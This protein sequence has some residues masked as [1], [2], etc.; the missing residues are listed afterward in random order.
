MTCLIPIGLTGAGM[1]LHTSMLGTFFVYTL[2]L[3]MVIFKKK[4]FV[5][6]FGKNFQTFHYSN[7][8]SMKRL[9]LFSRNLHKDFFLKISILSAKVYIQK[10]P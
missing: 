10:N 8:N 5:E 4:I 9:E 2:G 7:V 1:K 6:I 3:S